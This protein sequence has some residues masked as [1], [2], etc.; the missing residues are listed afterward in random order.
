MSL[1]YLRKILW[2]RTLSEACVNTP[3]N[4]EIII[5]SGA[6]E[7]N[8]QSEPPAIIRIRELLKLLEVYHRS[9]GFHLD[10]Y[11]RF[12][13]LVQQTSDTKLIPETQGIVVISIYN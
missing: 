11:L 13:M 10:E 3:S 12:R 7:V 9:A 1:E 4:E 8:R 5:I 2:N 6:L